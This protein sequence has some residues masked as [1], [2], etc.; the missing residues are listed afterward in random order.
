MTI[1]NCAHR[2]PPGTIIAFS[3]GAVGIILGCYGFSN[4]SDAMTSAGLKIDLLSVLY[5]CSAASL[6]NMCAL[7][8]ILC[9][10]N[11]CYGRKRVCIDPTCALCF[12]T[13]L[14]WLAFI[15]LLLLSYVLLSCWLILS[16]FSAICF[17]GGNVVMSVDT[18]I[19]AVASAGLQSQWAY[20][21][22]DLDVA[23]YCR[24]S[25]QL[26]SDGLAFF[27]G[28][29]CTV[30]SQAGIIAS[31]HGEKERLREERFQQD[32][33]A[34]DDFDGKSP[35][36]STRVSD[37]RYDAKKKESLERYG[38]LSDEDVHVKRSLLG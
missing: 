6:L 25:A 22:A 17:A 18:A 37:R 15:G 36:R 19:D 23:S 34:D 10:R 28:C 32:M 5:A 16:S 3:I 14:A 8:H 38:D 21:V 2:A 13:C 4:A 12:M 20:A 1:G 35:I 11:E 31:A 7:L 30:V 26:N 9:C 27:A 24:S 33:L 29:L